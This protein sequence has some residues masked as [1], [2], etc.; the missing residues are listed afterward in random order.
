MQSGPS[1][2]TMLQQAALTILGGIVVCLVGQFFSK[3]AFEPALGVRPTIAE[4]DVALHFYANLVS[5]VGS[6]HLEQD[7]ETVWKRREPA[8]ERFREL[9]ALLRARTQV[10]Y[11]CRL[12]AWI[13]LVPRRSKITRACADLIGLSNLVGSW[14]EG[15]MSSS[16]V[17]GEEI[18]QLLGLPY[19]KHAIESAKKI[20]QLEQ[21]RKRA[22]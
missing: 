5:S 8:A 17:L 20:Q 3:L 22:E 14:R 6:Q 18:R 19:S 15:S 9:S 2:E 13:R 7:A 4:I 11:A 16:I 10:V 21:H 1:L 12:A